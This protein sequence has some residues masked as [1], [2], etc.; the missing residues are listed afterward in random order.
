MNLIR[1]AI[2]A[3]CIGSIVTIFV[4]MEYPGKEY[5]INGKRTTEK[6]YKRDSP[7]FD[8]EVRKVFNI[9]ALYIGCLAAVGTFVIQPIRQ[10]KNSN[11]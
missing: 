6:K 9:T 8:S 4:N 1:N 3:I 7:W 10:K 2:L 5:F 11:Q